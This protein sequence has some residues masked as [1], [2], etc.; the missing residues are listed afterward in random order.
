MQRR[1]FLRTVGISTAGLAATPSTYPT[2]L[3]AG[4]SGT[5][6]ERPNILVMMADDHTYHDLGCAGNADV[7]TPNIDQLASEGMR[8]TQAFNSSP[9]C[10]P[11][12]MSLYTGIHPVRN[13]AY[14][15]HSRV[16]PDVRSMPQYLGDL[17]YQV[18]II[19]KRHE[20][21]LENFPFED[22]G[23]RHHDGGKGVDL[24]L[25]KVRAFL[26][27]NESD[28]W[29][30]V[31]SMNQPHRPWNR[32]VE[33]AYDPDALTLPPYLVD[34]PETRTALADYY[35]EIT[36]MDRQ[37]GGVLQ[38][39]AETGQA[40]NTIVVFLTEHGSNLPHCKWTCY[41]TGVRSTAVVRWPGTVAQGQ[42]SDAIVQYVDV[43]PT[44]LD[45]AGGSPE[46]HD[47]DG[48]SFLPVLTGERESHQEFAFSLQTSKGIYNGP[49]AYGIRSVRSP[50]Y[51][52]IW[53]LNW[54][55]EFQNLVTSRFPPYQSWKREAQKG[56]PFARE[57][58]QWYRKRPQFELYDL[59]ADPYEL[60]NRAEHTAYQSVRAHLK[61]ELDAWMAQQGDQGAQTERNALQR[62]A[63]RGK[64]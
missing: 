59:R 46:A 29:G 5:A 19:G 14:P 49:E 50:R 61:E 28:P 24:E 47:F 32:G 3:R 44:L 45:A 2:V 34:T 38:H 16:Y 57:R 12:R 13:G 7:Q 62:Q 23:G 54:E 48:R 35:A 1:D 26:E 4:E 39:L 40:E 9:M 33:Y 30:L 37:V 10:A 22:L 58:A 51:R 20:A 64:G 41:D 6:S 31:V 11:T 8:F 52:L 60:H 63:D 56:D 36:Y 27:E 42:V 21:P 15:N 53:N 17:G 18:G 43:L 25:S 55:Q